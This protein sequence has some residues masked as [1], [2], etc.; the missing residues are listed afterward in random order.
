MYRILQGQYLCGGRIP[1]HK[2]T[3][4]LYGIEHRFESRIRRDFYMLMLDGSL[5]FDYTS[6]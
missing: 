6:M 1:F 3:D 4:A 5:L 2:L